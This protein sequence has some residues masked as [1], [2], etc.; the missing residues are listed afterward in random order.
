MT[1]DK[2]GPRKFAD[3]PWN[4]SRSGNYGIFTSAGS[5]PLEYLLTTFQNSELS[6]LQ[7]V[8]EVKPEDDYDFELLM[9]R[10]IDNTP[11]IGAVDKLKEY[12]I[13]GLSGDGSRP[14]RAHSIF[15]PPLLVACVPCSDNRIRANYPAEKWIDDD[16]SVTRRWGNLFQLRFWKA[17]TDIH[18][19]FELRCSSTEG[20]SDVY[21][22]GVQARFN[23]SSGIQH[24]I[25]LVAIDG[26]HRLKAM[27]DV[28][29]VRTTESY[30][31]PVCILFAT[32]TSDQS[33]HPVTNEKEVRLPNVHQTFRKVFV[34]VNTNMTPVGS[35]F[36][37]LLDDTSVGSLIIREF[38]NRVS[39]EGK[40]YLS[41]V[42]W[43][44][45]GQKDATK[46]T[47]EYSITSI[48]IL[49]KALSA[50]F[51]KKSDTATLLPRLLD[52]ESVVTRDKLSSAAT[53]VGNKRIEWTGFSISQR[54]IITPLIREGIVELLFKIFFETGPFKAAAT[55]F[56]A[57]LKE[58]DKNSDPM[59]S[60][61][62]HYSVED[63]AEA[64]RV[65]TTHH[66]K[67][68]IEKG[69][70][71]RKLIAKL[72]EDEARKRAKL[73]PVMGLALFQRSMILSLRQIM[74]VLDGYSIQD[75]APIFLRILE[76]SMN[77][78]LKLFSFNPYTFN[79]I[80][81]DE[82][83]I[84]NIDRTCTQL[85]RLTLSICGSPLFV[86]RIISV[87]EDESL[88]AKFAAEQL[89][90][91]GCSSANDYW[92][93]YKEDRIQDFKNNYRTR[94]G[95]SED[96]ITKLDSAKQDQ[97]EESL[98]EKP[99]DRLVEDHLDDDFKNAKKSLMKKLDFDFHASEDGYSLD[100]VESD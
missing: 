68:E 9:Q 57:E 90:D 44:V 76:E 82:T 37:I 40:E 75:V 71:S 55:S 72:G 10:D 25:K 49:E 26:Q 85:S 35:H 13:P 33:I 83:N 14:M 21:S 66:N 18:H 28:S 43:N 70:P 53:H 7:L 2:D 30:A 84:K 59:T 88:G 36:S 77:N 51:G 63:Y 54:E 8:R 11:I 48:G 39:Q 100:E 46:L 1:Q 93:Q 95:L 34:D 79:T 62:K 4:F 22:D 91:L 81:K 19:K 67:L 50:C 31:V 80:W 24:G 15:F 52:I 5:V 92:K 87:D 42:E 27:K 45:R 16:K 32:Y 17:T 86:Q 74:E 3:D 58:W 12:L 64:Y 73:S 99:F 47:R 61:S 20:K 6:V 23:I 41:G 97:Q 78:K 69:E 29:R 38:C 65:C 56:I 96:D 94:L 98:K 89:R 60:T